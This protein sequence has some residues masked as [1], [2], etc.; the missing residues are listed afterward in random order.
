M[1]D[2]HLPSLSLHLAVAPDPVALGDTVAI[3]ITI[4]NDA[5][6]P[7]YDLVLTLP[8]PDGALAASGPNTIS[9]TK[10]WQWTLKSLDGH[11]RMTATGRLRVV[12][13][14]VGDA[15][16]LRAEVKVQN[17][18]RVCAKTF[19]MIPDNFGVELRN[20]VKY[21]RAASCVA[22]LAHLAQRVVERSCLG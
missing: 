2:L 13:R 11:S 10:G 16:L 17:A 12:Q 3:T 5:P 18:P 1:L 14:P 20:T 19:A 7:V 4:A 9:P 22:R 21:G 6:N 8:T 15:V